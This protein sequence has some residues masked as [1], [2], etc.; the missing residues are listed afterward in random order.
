MRYWWVNQNQTYTA[1]ISGGYVWSPKRNKNGARNQ[2]YENMREV[3]PGDLIFSF[4]DRRITTFG[5]VT[6]NC[7]ESP[8]PDEFGNAGRNWGQVGWR[9]DVAYKEMSNA[10]IPKDHIDVIRPLLP[11]KYSPIQQNGDGLQNV[12]LASISAEF[13]EV[14]KSLLIKAGNDLSIAEDLTR[15]DQSESI[16]ER[17]ERFL[18]DEIRQSTK[19]G[20][21][22]KEQIVKSRRGQGLFRENVQKHEKQCRITGVGDTRFLIASHIK[23]WRSSDNHERLDGENGLLLTPNIDLLFDRGFISFGDNGDLLISPVLE[24]PLLILLGV[25][26]NQTVN[27]GRF[28]SGQRKY[29]EYHRKEIFLKAGRES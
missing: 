10:I 1:E 22:E 18:E 3:S 20:S 6:S 15:L 19:L 14:L 28:T 27:V 12:Y 8:K 9:A 7:Y 16:H 29:L 21:T 11:D 5:V 26:V 4:R 2:F 17:V 13:A 24:N 25:N 23:P